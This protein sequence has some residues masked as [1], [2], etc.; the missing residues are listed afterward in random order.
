MLAHYAQNLCRRQPTDGHVLMKKR[1]SCCSRPSSE[2]CT[3][4]TSPPLAQRFP[5]GQTRELDGA[6]EATLHAARCAPCAVPSRCAC[7]YKLG[8]ALFDGHDVA[9]AR[10]VRF[11][12]HAASRVMIL[13]SP[14]LAR[15]RVGWVMKAS[16]SR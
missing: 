3:A 5:A 12:S 1:S 7:A 8:L 2:R 15:R 9:L 16:A 14:L 4:G 6:V 10:R 13:N 11:A